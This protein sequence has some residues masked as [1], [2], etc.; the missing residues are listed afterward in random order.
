MQANII[1]NAKLKPEII[2][3]RMEQCLPEQGHEPRHR[4]EGK[5][6]DFGGIPPT[7]EIEGGTGKGN[8]ERNHVH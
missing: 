6:E 7:A 3:Q 8:A 2:K 1:L 5:D 4:N